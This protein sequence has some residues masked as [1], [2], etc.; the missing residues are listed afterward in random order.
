MIILIGDAPSL[1]PPL[2]KYTLEDVIHKAKEDKI[3]M[4][5]Y[6]IL[7]SPYDKEDLG[8]ARRMEEIKM[9]QAIYPNPTS[10]LLNIDFIKESAYTVDLLNRKGEIIYSENVRGSNYKKELNELENGLYIV[11]VTDRYKN[12][13]NGKIVLQ[14]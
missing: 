8:V 5:F 12:F 10:G 11:R 6:P 3:N 4:N 1:L 2:S 14:R 9:I 13:D 7:I